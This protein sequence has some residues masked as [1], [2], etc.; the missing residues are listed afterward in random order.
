VELSRIHF[1][2]PQNTMAHRSSVDEQSRNCKHEEKSTRENKGEIKITKTVYP[3]NLT[4]R[5]SRWLAM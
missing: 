1:A 3:R 2:S 4:M 5:E